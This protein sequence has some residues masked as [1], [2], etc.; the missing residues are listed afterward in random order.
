MY[1]CQGRT[2]N[3]PSLRFFF[4]SGE[5]DHL[6]GDGDGAVGTIAAGTCRTP[7][8]GGCVRQEEKN[9]WG[10]AGAILWIVGPRGGALGSNIKTVG[11]E[12]RGRYWI[13]GVEGGALGEETV[14]LGVKNSL[15]GDSPYLL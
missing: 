7:Y 4:P 3:L 15:A 5:V 11:A 9:Y 13:S 2:Y 12:A 6:G 1:N 14:T 8:N 10:E